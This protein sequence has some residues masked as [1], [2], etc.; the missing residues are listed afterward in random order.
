MGSPLDL[1]RLFGFGPADLGFGFLFVGL[2]A[3]TFL[4]PQRAPL[5]RQGFQGV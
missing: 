1:S 5:E 4:V 2:S 3:I